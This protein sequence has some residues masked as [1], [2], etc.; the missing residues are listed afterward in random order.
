MQDK[1]K[2]AQLCIAC[3]TTLIALA[4]VIVASFAYLSLDLGQ[5][6]SITA[7]EDMLRFFLSFFPPDLSSEFI[8][9]KD[10]LTGFNQ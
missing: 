4:V 3:L 6:I 10:C 9:K 2:A 5:L 1:A 8:A 7:A